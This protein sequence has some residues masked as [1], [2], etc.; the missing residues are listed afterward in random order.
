MLCV[1]CCVLCCVALCLAMAETAGN[2]RFWTRCIAVAVS[3]PLHIHGRN[4]RKPA[5]L[6]TRPESHRA[7]PWTQFNG[8]KGLRVVLDMGTELAPTGFGFSWSQHAA[9]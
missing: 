2:L 6:D 3:L 1:L 4:R 5:V 8:M 7:W 9:K